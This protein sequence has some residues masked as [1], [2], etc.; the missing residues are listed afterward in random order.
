LRVEGQ[1]IVG[2][3]DETVMLRGA[4]EMVIWSAERDGQ[5]WFDE[6][7]ALGAN[8]V[9]VVWLPFGTGEELD[10]VIGNAIEAG[11][12]VV[13]EQH[14]PRFG[15]DEE[16]LPIDDPTIADRTVEY[17]T[18]DEILPVLIEH[19]ASIIFEFGEKLGDF[20]EVEDWASRFEDMIP[21]F[22]NAGIRAPLA[23]DAPYGGANV[24][25]F[26]E[27]AFRVLDADPL[28]NSIWSVEAWGGPTEDRAARMR[29]IHEAGIPFFLSEFSGFDSVD[30]PTTPTDV[31]LLLSTLQDLDVGWFAW[32]WGGVANSGCEANGALDMTT[33]GHV[34]GLTGWGLEVA[35]T[36]ENSI[37]KTA[38]KLGSVV[39]AE[40]Q[41]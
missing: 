23:L 6:M 3:C 18:S 21:R 36:D 4:N 35:Q 2:R 41:L 33:D 28:G 27:G 15:E 5:P 12:I 24:E 19:E 9:R 30:C 40:C 1:R 25:K 13:V 39:G 7:A 31:A 16:E 38:I 14:Q 10:R 8:A 20:D 11:L 17:W 22:R 32:S 37:A 29:A 34:S 26:S